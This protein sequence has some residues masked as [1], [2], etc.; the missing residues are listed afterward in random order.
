MKKKKLLK[1]LTLNKK[2]I[3]DFKVSSSKGGSAANHCVT[4]IFDPPSCACFTGWWW[5]C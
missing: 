4:G 2:V 1:D 5:F 3:S